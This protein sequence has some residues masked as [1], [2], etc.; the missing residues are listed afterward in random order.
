[1]ANSDTIRWDSRVSTTM[2][3]SLNLPPI[4]QII[5]LKL[6]EFLCRRCGQHKRAEGIVARLADRYL[7]RKELEKTAQ[8]L[9]L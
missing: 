7:E 9:A 6:S 8:D 5:W 1:V 4:H 3:N 2:A